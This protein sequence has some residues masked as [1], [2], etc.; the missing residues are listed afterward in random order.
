[1]RLVPPWLVVQQGLQ[2]V[3]GGHD[4]GAG[5]ARVVGFDGKAV[6]SCCSLEKVVVGLG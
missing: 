6:D 3:V 4:F 2:H 1:M 5:V